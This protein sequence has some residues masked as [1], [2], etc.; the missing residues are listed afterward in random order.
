MSYQLWQDISFYL[1]EINQEKSA[2]AKGL[3]TPELIESAKSKI[4]LI[5]DQLK[6]SLE[7]KLG[8]EHSSLILF[9]IVASVD[10]EMQGF[11]YNHLKVRW[12]PLQKDFYSAYTAGEVF[13]KTVDEILDNPSIPSMVYEAFYFILKS[14]F[15]G[16][17]RDSKTQLTKYIDLL[18]QKIQVISP[19]PKPSVIEDNEPVSTP[20]KFGKW[21]YYGFALSLLAI[22]YLGLFVLSNMAS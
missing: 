22:T 2:F 18:R 10:E 14:G 4:S 9:A 21:H 5:L 8:K 20:K 15:K 7:I 1:N 12:T 3:I 19:N 11:N 13:F 6:T 16:K 17:Y